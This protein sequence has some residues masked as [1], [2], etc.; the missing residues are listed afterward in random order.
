MKKL[1]AFGLI[2]SS[3]ASTRQPDPAL[4]AAIRGIRAIDN[5]SHPPAL[6]AAGQKD[7]DFDDLPCDPL[8]PTNPTINGSPENPRFKAA[9]KAKF[10]YK[11]NDAD[12][13]HVRAL[14]AAKQRMKTAKGDNY[15]AWVLDQLGIETELAN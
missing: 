14:I 7:D 8:E 15:P 10:G 1:L 11:Y 13:A 4:L 9:R 5:H 3:H 12:S 6:V 2:I